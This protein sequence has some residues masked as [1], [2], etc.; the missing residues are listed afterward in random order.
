MRAAY[1]LAR[2]QEVLQTAAQRRRIAEL[3]KIPAPTLKD[4]FSGRTS[5]PIDRFLRIAFAA[6]V[7]PVE[8][9]RA[10][11]LMAS[12]AAEPSIT[13]VPVLDID[14]AAGPGIRADVVKAV[15]DLPFPTEFIRKLAPVG[16]D[17]SS[18]RC[19]GDSMAPT[20][21]NGA[22]LIIDE[23]QKKPRPFR[24]PRKRP[25]E[26]PQQD[27]IFVFIQGGDL[28]L[29]RLRDLG[30]GLIAILS[31]NRHSHPIEIIKPGRDGALAVIGKVIWWDNRL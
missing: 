25:R 11:A 4:Y 20:I 26:A 19:S 28:R 10:P 18:L 1:V 3:T 6:G 16:A 31:D 7:D 29:K 24:S 23:R 22:L 15:G 8:F 21:K 12:G 5:P 2:L 13:I 27:D 14:A 17:L 30:D 9:L